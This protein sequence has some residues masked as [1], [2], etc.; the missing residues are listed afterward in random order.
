MA[1]DLNQGFIDQYS[2]YWTRK[3]ALIIATNANQIGRHRPKT[4][5]EDELFSEDLY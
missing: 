3:E 4:W 2:N 5:A 1:Y